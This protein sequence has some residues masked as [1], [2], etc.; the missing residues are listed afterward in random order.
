M[1]LP[2]ETT[3]KTKTDYLLLLRLFRFWN[4]Y[5]RSAAHVACS[6][7]PPRQIPLFSLTREL[8]YRLYHLTLLTYSLIYLLIILTG[9]QLPDLA[10]V[11]ASRHGV[12]SAHWG[13]Y[14]FPLIFATTAF[15]LI[16]F[17]IWATN[18]LS[19]RM[20]SLF[21]IILLAFLRSNAMASTKFL[22]IN[23]LYWSPLIGMN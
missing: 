13:R 23:F 4:R 12:R 20:D 17:V 11:L 3:R 8:H 15:Q 22:G 5:I 9:F 10:K 14:S 1:Q 6:F 19:T 2:G 21:L 16:N 7:F 18:S